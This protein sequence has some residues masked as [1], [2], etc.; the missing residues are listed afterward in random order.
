MPQ[1]NWGQQSESAAHAVE[2]HVLRV[3]TIG[4]VLGVV[5]VPIADIVV[6]GIVNDTC[7]VVEAAPDGIV[8]ETAGG[9]GVEPRKVSESALVELAT[10]EEG[11]EG[12]IVAPPGVDVV[13]VEAGTEW[14]WEPM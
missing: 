2:E 7:D 4:R 6:D 13:V 10:I 8:N 3:V 12:P 14:G 11:V 9:I 1:M 5:D